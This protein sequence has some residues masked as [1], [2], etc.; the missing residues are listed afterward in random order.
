M[1]EY[2]PNRCNAF[3]AK[4]LEVGT[5][6][7]LDNNITS[8]FESQ[9]IMRTAISAEELPLDQHHYSRQQIR[10]KPAE[11]MICSLILSPPAARSLSKR[12]VDITGAAVALLML[13]PLMLLLAV[14]IRLDSRGSILF[15]QRRMGLEGREFWFYKFRTMVP[16]AERF[17]SNLEVQNESTG[18]VLFKI[19]SDPRVTKIGRF[20]RRTSLDELPQFFNVLK[21]DMSLVG[22]RPLQLRD[23]KRL[24]THDPEGFAER[25]SVPQGLTGPWQI[26]GRSDA[27][28]DTMLRLDLDY[29]ANWSLARDLQIL[30]LTV[31][32]VLAGR[33]AC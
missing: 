16:D 31:P 2:S 5:A 7:T 9:L 18:G 27:D 13:A 15:R 14:L 4:T 32:A 29:V 25:L 33:G 8:C 28:G 22:P 21:G 20:L 24:Q 3:P 17:L 19:K 10:L 11:A 12:V 30:V 26:G 23:C 1:L 6:K